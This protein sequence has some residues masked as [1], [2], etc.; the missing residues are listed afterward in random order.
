MSYHWS[1]SVFPED[2]EAIEWHKQS[3]EIAIAEANAKAEWKAFLD[4]LPAW[5]RQWSEA[6]LRR[7]KER[8]DRA[9]ECE[10]QRAEHEGL[11]VCGDDEWA[12]R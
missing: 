1:H 10:A 11:M 2:L 12:R 4:S 7:L 3:A 6:P 9:L 8:K 5:Q